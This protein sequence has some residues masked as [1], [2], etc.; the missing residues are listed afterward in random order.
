MA[1]AE[2]P[3]T[4][5]SVQTDD[6]ESEYSYE[7]I[8][9]ANI[10]R[11]ELRQ[12]EFDILRRTG[13]LGHQRTNDGSPEMWDE[14]TY[15]PPVW[16]R[17]R[18]L[19]VAQALVSI[20]RYPLQT[21]SM[22]IQYSGQPAQITQRL[23]WTA[24]LGSMYQ[25]LAGSHLGVVGLAVRTLVPGEATSIKGMV[26]GVAL[27]YGIFGLLYGVFRQSTVS[28]LQLASPKGPPSIT[29]CIWPALTWI[30][31]RILLRGPRGSILPLYLRD[32]A[33]N[34][35]QAALSMY[36]T[37]LL[38]SSTAVRIY[39]GILRA[40]PQKA[41]LAVDVVFHREPTEVLASKGELLIYTQAIA[42][43]VAAVTTR[44]VF[45]P[46][47]SVILRLMADEVGLTRLAYKGFF[48]CLGRV[49]W[50]SLFDG[51]AYTAVTELSLAWLAAEIAHYLCKSA[52]VKLH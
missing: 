2:S 6:T 45:Y 44:M 18:A 38:T 3:E 4:D 48:D 30:Q 7:Q 32:V 31:D 29:N 5:Q 13:L 52:W 47:D 50:W 25:W 15:E 43:L 40:R 41:D 51:F 9:A 22:Y 27:H 11:L 34:A 12:A 26:A 16:R 8:E 21:S 36:V 28:R 35:L 37:R 17:S 49:S 42:S 20:L 46:V 10:E 1:S 39:S 23:L 14:S 24:P 33:G 19:T